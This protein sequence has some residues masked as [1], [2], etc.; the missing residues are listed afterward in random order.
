MR[1]GMRTLALLLALLALGGSVGATC[2][3]FA[4]WLRPENEVSGAPR[5]SVPEH[6]RPK[7]HRVQSALS[8]RWQRAD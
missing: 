7:R 2:P 8:P 6:R 1:D 5:S 4:A 3:D